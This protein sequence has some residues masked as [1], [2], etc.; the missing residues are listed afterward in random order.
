MVGR[1]SS[2][3]W[4]VWERKLV[5]IRMEYGGTSAVLYWKN[6]DEET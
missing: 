5:S 1:S 2:L 3:C 6:K 4:T